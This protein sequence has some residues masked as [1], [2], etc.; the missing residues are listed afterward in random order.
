MYISLHCL[1]VC[2]I[3]S[4]TS[5]AQTSLGHLLQYLCFQ[6]I[7]WQDFPSSQNSGTLK[8]HPL[9]VS[10]QESAANH[11]RSVFKVNN[12]FGMTQVMLKHRLISVLTR[13]HIEMYKY[14]E[15]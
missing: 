4:P 8:T 10:P 15:W 1:G 7:I 6:P 12:S 11:M 3:V 9:S 14:P 2:F 13:M 5:L